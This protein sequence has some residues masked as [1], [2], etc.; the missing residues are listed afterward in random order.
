[1]KEELYFHIRQGGNDQDG[2][3]PHT[4][5]VK[6]KDNDLYLGYSIVNKNDQFCRRT[7]RELAKKIAS[8][9]TT[10]SDEHYILQSGPA[11]PQSI[12]R[13]I[14]DVVQKSGEILGFSGKV[15]V[16]SIIRCNNRK[17]PI[18]KI[19]EITKVLN[20]ANDK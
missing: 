12:Q 1:M 6:Y 19:F 4:Y 2:L 3:L 8:A 5:C 10:I 14:E 9:A 7:G 15:Y 11:Y 18:A 20:S 13:S 16:K 17:V